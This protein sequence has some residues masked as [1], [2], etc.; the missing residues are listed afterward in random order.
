MPVW[1]SEGQVDVSTTSASSARADGQPIESSQLDRSRGGS[2]SHIGTLLLGYYAEDGRL[3]YACRASTGMTANELN[4][5][6]SGWPRCRCRV[7]PAPVAGEAAA[8]AAV[9]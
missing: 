5:R 4:A 7:P 6:W 3:G 8:L 9:F 1:L 2:P